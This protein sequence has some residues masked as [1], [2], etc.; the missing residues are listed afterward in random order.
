MSAMAERMLA[1]AGVVIP[2]S[3]GGNTQLPSVPVMSG[4]IEVALNITAATNVFKNL[5]MCCCS[6]LC[7]AMLCFSVLCYVVFFCAVLCCAVLCYHTELC[8]TH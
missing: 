8:H 7:Y 4:E 5:G 2:D 3:V 6:R 1:A